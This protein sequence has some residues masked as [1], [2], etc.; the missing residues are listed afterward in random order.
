MQLR[1]HKEWRCADSGTFEKAARG[2]GNAARAMISNKA[3]R[4][5]Y[6]DLAD[7]CSDLASAIDGILGNSDFRR[8]VPIKR[9]P[10]R[11]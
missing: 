5:R 9:A 3:D 8:S 6:N 1:C 10:Q 7:R 11:V 2:T 4:N